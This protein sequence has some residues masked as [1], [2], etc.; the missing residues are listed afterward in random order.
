MA[1][2]PP[3][4]ASTVARFSFP[5]TR[6]RYGPSRTNRGLQQAAEESRDTIQAHLFPA[7][8]KTIERLPE[9]LRTTSVVEGHAAADELRTAQEGGKTP[10]DRLR[11]D[12][13]EFG[14]VKYEVWSAAV[15][16]EGPAG[17]NVWWQVVATEV[18]RP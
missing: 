7:S 16:L 14:G 6:I 13:L 4:L 17:A 15:W 9:G 5:V 12:V 18:R 11:P 1:L 2:G 10:G 8:A 3:R